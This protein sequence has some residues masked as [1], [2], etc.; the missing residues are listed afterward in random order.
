MG[1]YCRKQ[2]RKQKKQELDQ[3]SDSKKFSWPS[4]CF[5]DRFL[6]RVLV[7]LFFSS[8][9]SW[10]SSFFLVFFYKFPP[11][12]SGLLLSAS[13]IFYHNHNLCP[14]YLKNGFHK[15]PSVCFSVSFLHRNFILLIFY[16]SFCQ[17]Q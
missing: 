5:L 1:I 14:S 16:Q 2:V 10:S 12:S 13:R 6:G 17:F 15:C 8:S 11:L 3:E 9:L 7:F 4:S